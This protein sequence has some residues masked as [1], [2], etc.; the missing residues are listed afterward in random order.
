MYNNY[1]IVMP[2]G[3]EPDEKNDLEKLL[4]QFEKSRKKRRDRS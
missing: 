1:I 3:A 2:P 4:I